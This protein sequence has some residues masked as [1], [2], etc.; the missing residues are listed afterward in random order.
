MASDA[1]S[2]WADPEQFRAILLKLQ[3]RLRGDVDQMTDEAL[4]RG[5]Q[6]G[7]GNL[8]SVP[9]HIADLGTDNYDQE[10]TLGLIENEQETL[11]EIAEALGRIEGGTFGLCGNCE[12][13]I[14]K[15][16]LQALPYTRYCIECA[17]LSEG[18][19]VS[20]SD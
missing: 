10:F 7:G 15:A 1:R 3:S 4:N 2:K 5:G 11:D 19:G 16:R 18:A 13:P 12:R 14:A 9:L 17:R 6:E 8:S 20:S